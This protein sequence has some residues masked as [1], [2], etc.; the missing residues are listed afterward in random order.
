MFIPKQK[1]FR[2][3]Q[4]YP[5]ITLWY[6]PY[7][8]NISKLSFPT[9]AKGRSFF[10]INVGKQRLAREFLTESERVSRDFSAVPYGVQRVRGNN[11]PTLNPKMLWTLEQGLGLGL[12]KA[13]YCYRF[14]FGGLPAHP[15]QNRLK[16]NHLSLKVLEV[17]NGASLK[18][19]A[20]GDGIVLKGG[21]QRTGLPESNNP[22]PY[23][24][25]MYIYIYIYIHLYGYALY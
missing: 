22:K 16:V 6:K 7:T 5:L 2:S 3:T 25:H 21:N 17:K 8:L 1:V 24:L 23:I 9:L 18:I 4:T 10:G 11:I 15:N 20:A 19:Q 12:G 13:W 14:T